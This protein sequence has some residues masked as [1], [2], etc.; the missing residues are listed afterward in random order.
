MSD[1]SP[2]GTPRPEATAPNRNSL[3]TDASKPTP[4]PNHNPAPTAS[5]G[6]PGASARNE[7]Q[8]RPTDNPTAKTILNPYKPSD[9]HRGKAANMDRSLQR[10]DS[11]TIRNR[12]HPPK[13]RRW[14]IGRGNNQSLPA[15]WIPAHPEGSMEASLQA[16]MGQRVPQALAGRLAQP[17]LLQMARWEAR[18]VRRPNRCLEAKL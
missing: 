6:G 18:P 11:N 3:L 13:C 17:E 1:R 16:R 12:A 9:L 7:K 8:P 14:T 15:E 2:P 10:T 4:A 5:R